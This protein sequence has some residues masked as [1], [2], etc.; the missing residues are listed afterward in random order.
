MLA[1][2]CYQPTSAKQPKP[3]S[4][5]SCG[6]EA[7]LFLRPRRSALAALWDSCESGT[8]CG[9]GED[10]GYEQTQLSIAVASGAKRTR[11]ASLLD[12]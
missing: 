3:N 2:D 5:V 1:H 8:P 4:V 9:G 7:E 6:R 12:A 11:R 10:L